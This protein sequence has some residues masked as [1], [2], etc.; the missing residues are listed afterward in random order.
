M[1]P[2]KGPRLQGITRRRRPKFNKCWGQARLR[3]ASVSVQRQ[4]QRQV[5]PGV[6]PAS[7]ACAVEMRKW[8]MAQYPVGQRGRASACASCACFGIAVDSFFLFGGFLFLCSL[9]SCAAGEQKL[10]PKAQRLLRVGDTNKKERWCRPMPVQA[11][12]GRDVGWAG[13]RANSRGGHQQQQ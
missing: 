8:R 2:P 11:K 3:P 1:S 4:R 6:G 10:C 7:C 5:R 13:D 12:S 9:W